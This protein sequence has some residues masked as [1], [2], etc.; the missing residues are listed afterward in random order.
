MLNSSREKMENKRTNLTTDILKLNKK[1]YDTDRHKQ[2]D[3][4]QS[5]YIHTS[6][7]IT[8]LTLKTENIA[9]RRHRRWGEQWA[10]TV[11]DC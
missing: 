3:P 11:D 2:P 9:D 5:N 8:L 4:Q 1:P 6:R 7:A 10:M